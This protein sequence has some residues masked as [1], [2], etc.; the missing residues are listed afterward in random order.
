MK[1]EL[2]F[3]VGRE[4][5]PAW[6][7]GIFL[8][9]RPVDCFAFASGSGAH[10]LAHNERPDCECATITMFVEG[11]KRTFPALIAAC[12]GANAFYVL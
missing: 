12:H 10:I 6:H 2:R 3:L 8:F 11:E 1:R 5:L 4:K 7:A 9:D